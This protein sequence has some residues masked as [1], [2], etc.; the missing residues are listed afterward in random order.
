MKIAIIPAA[1]PNAAVAELSAHLE[2]ISGR[3]YRT[4]DAPHSRRLAIAGMIFILTL[5]LD[6]AEV[7]ARYE[8]PEMLFLTLPLMIYWISRIW[9]LSARGKIGG[10]PVVYVFRDR[11]SLICGALLLSILWLSA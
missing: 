10:D 2:A 11:P 4:Q 3:A 1:A 8:N 6:S 5:Y 7:R 9:L